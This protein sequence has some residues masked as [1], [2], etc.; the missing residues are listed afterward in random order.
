[1][2][3]IILSLSVA[4]L[5]VTTNLQAKECPTT[6]EKIGFGTLGVLQGLFIGGPVGAFWGLG[7]VIYANNYEDSACA[8]KSTE[9]EK[10][11]SNEVG[12]KAEQSSAKTVQKVQEKKEVQEQ[13]Q[14]V[15][16]KL[17]N[18]SQKTN[19]ESINKGLVIIP[20][21]VQF[22]YNSFKVPNVPKKLSSLKND[23]ITSIIVDGHTDSVGS[24]EFN[25]AL[26]LK[27]ANAVKTILVDQ[28]IESE[29]LS[30]VSYGESNPISN[31]D[32]EN[33]RV[34]LNIKYSAAQ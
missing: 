12:P 33:R 31:N 10:T 15:D 24:D 3:K 21:I 32:A 13:S 8:D 14:S 2:K 22:E 28:G 18:I 34:D 6:C 30:I 25:F 20:S 23:D 1:M 16:S 7:T 29:K 4:T 19:T 17:D 27:R 9:T 26:G 5:L 11:K